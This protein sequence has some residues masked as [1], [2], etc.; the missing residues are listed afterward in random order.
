MLYDKLDARAKQNR[1]SFAMPGHK[2][3]KWIPE[4]LQGLLEIDGTELPGTDNMHHPEGILRESLDA[5]ATAYG[6]AHSYFSVNGSSAG[7]LSALHFAASRSSEI[8]IDRNCHASAINALCLTGLSPIYLY[9][10]S[11]PSFGITG[12]VLPEDIAAALASHPAAGFVF[13]TSPNY[14]GICS[15]IRAIAGIVHAAGKLLIV[16]EAHGAH[17]GF[18]PLL[19]ESAVRQGADIVIQSAHKTLP[20]PNQTALI[21]ISSRIDPAKF[22][23]WYSLFQTTSPSY[24]LMA[25]TDYAVHF[26]AECGTEVYQTLHEQISRLE[27]PFPMLSVGTAHHD[28]TR[29]VFHTAAFGIH[30]Y[31]AAAYLDKQGIDVEM[32][33]CNNVVC[34]ATGGNTD[35][36]FAALET[37]LSACPRGNAAPLFLAPPHARQVML[38][39]EAFLSPTELLPPEKAA[40]RISAAVVASFP[41][42]VPILAPGEEIT[43]AHIV[44]LR[45]IQRLGGSVTG[46]ENGNFRVVQQSHFL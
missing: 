28:F 46:F 8:L 2:G 14:F 18:S 36:D 15:D 22:S 20:A 23:R 7:I 5:I 6:A 32:A 4:R 31:D 19:P 30:G 12:A 34:I 11:V 39:R 38:P 45:E 42:C 3:G 44:Y 21:H 25:L 27:T 33:D 37:A 16:D 17:F 9:P 13:L 41:P 26:Q 1:I 43:Q 29:L 10:Q 40:G 35:A 24:P